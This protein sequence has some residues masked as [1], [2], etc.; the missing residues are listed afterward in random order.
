MHDVLVSRGYRLIDDAWDAHGRFTYIHGDD[1][2]RQYLSSLTQAVSAE[3]WSR[4]Q[5]QLRTYR[6]L[7]TNETIEI[8]PGG[9]ETSGHF[10]HLLK[11]GQ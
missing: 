5:D 7:G 6:H 3:G 10:L 4:S 8:E 9:S 11:P 2:D 1:V